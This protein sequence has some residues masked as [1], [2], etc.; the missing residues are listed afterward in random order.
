MKFLQTLLYVLI[1]ANTAYTQGKIMLVGGG[2]ELDTEWSWSNQPYSWAITESSN[3]RVAIISFGESS[4]PQW[5]PNYFNTLGANYAR[6][7]IINTRDSSESQVLYD[8]LMKYDV[9]FFKGGDQSNYYDTYINSQVTAAINDKYNQGG[10]IGGTSAGMAIL[11]GVVYTA[12][13]SSVFPDEVMRDGDSNNITLKDDFVDILPGFMTDTHFIER[14]RF[15]RLIAFLANWKINQNESLKGIGV[16]DRTAFCIDENLIG[17]VYGT[18]AVSVFYGE[19]YSIANEQLST[20]SVNVVSILHEHQ[21]DLNTHEL[22]SSYKLNSIAQ[23]EVIITNK[24]TYITGTDAITDNQDL[25]DE[26]IE[27][28]DSV[29]FV[30]NNQGSFSNSY[31]Q[32]LEGREASVMGVFSSDNLDSCSSVEERNFIKN[33][34]KLVFAGNGENLISFLNETPTGRL[35]NDHIRRSDVSVAFLGADAKLVGSKYPA[36]NEDDPLNAYYGDLEIVDGLGIVNSSII[37]PNAFDPTTTDYYENNTAAVQLSLIQDQLL[38]A[39]LI[40]KGSYVR[41]DSQNNQAKFT[42]YGIYS[43]VLVKNISESAGIADQQVNSEGNTRNVVGYDQLQVSFLSDQT[44]N[45]G[46]ID[47]TAPISYQFDLETPYNLSA[48][49]NDEIIQLTW[50]YPDEFKG[51]FIIEKRFDSNQFMEIGSSSSTNFEDP[52]ANNGEYRVKAVSDNQSSCYSEVIDAEVIASLKK[53]L[54]EKIKFYPN[55]ISSD[56]LSI[57]LAVKSTIQILALDG[58]VM[59]ERIGR[60]GVNLLMVKDLPQGMYILRIK[61]QGE[62]RFIKYYKIIKSN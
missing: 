40:N 46:G 1:C 19:E 51:N 61:S 27:Q 2:T 59:I 31:L 57:I 20:D 38:W 24:S 6:N 16:D 43:S 54:D 12:E 33:S 44:I 23:N 10:V 15:P 5:L 41:V 3:K 30:T 32:N 11:A 18:G 26:L 47:A 14:G 17:T 7:F 36:N 42:N 49:E 29:V 48:I 13:E 21:F 4:D 39:L 34:G 35:L 45:A 56:K 58:S 37:I 50:D 55:P 52:Q 53:N 9:F 25:F 28:N 8:T 62:S 60:E 22:L